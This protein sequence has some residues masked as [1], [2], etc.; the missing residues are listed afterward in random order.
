M[1][2]AVVAS[3]ATANAVRGASPPMFIRSGI[4]RVAYPSS[5]ALRAVVI[6]AVCDGAY[7]AT[8][9][10]RNGLCIWVILLSSFFPLQET[11]YELLYR[12]S[13]Q[14]IYIGILYSEI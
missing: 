1:R 9:P 6:Q 10:K 2:S 5:S 4:N 11:Q 14:L 13:I 12:Q 8:T 3:A 7:A